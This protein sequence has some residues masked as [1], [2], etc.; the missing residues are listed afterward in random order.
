MGYREP[1]VLAVFCAVGGVA[2]AAAAT[3]TLSTT[4]ND[5]ANGLTAPLRTLQKAATLLQDGDTLVFQ[6]GTYTAGVYITRRNITLR[7]VGDVVLNGSG[8]TRDDGISFSQTSGITLEN[9]KVRNCRRMGIFVTLS[10][11]LTIRN[12]EVSAN[13]GSGILTG[14]TSD[15]LVENCAAFSNGSHGVYLSQSGDRLTVRGNRLYNNQ[16][17]GLQ[18]NAVQ[19]S[20]TSDPNS[21]SLSKN[22]TVEGNTIYGNGAVGGSAINLMGVQNSQIA[23]N[24]IYNNLAGGIALWDDGAGAAYACKNNRVLH[25]TVVFPSGKGRYGVQFLAGSTGNQLYNNILVVGAGSAI[26]AAVAVQSN[27]NCLSAPTTANGGSLSAW[28]NST[29]NDQNSQSGNP[30]LTADYHLSATSAARD[31]GYAMLGTDKDGRL[32]PQGPNPDVGCYEEIYGSTTPTPPTPPTPPPTGTATVLYA[33]ALVSGWTATSSKAQYNL[34][35]TSPV[36]TGSRSVAL[37][38]TGTDGF[39]RIA[40]AG[41]SVS[42]KSYLKLAVHGGATGGQQLRIRSIVNGVQQSNSLNLRSYGALPVANGWVEYAIPL[43]DLKAAQGTLTGLKLFAGQAE[44]LA[45]LDNIRLE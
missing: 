33:D 44:K 8:A 32:R 15:V 35:A 40:G 45:Y 21:D 11:G 38:I 10:S 2:P 19:P 12:C 34:A 25:N 20:P 41:V 9:L 37:T 5:A 28:Q 4:G 1:L 24:L 23:N 43:A 13:T 42:G 31:G 7:G 16:R 22:C 36:N 27:Y 26:E 17:A 39:L 3:Y 30:G 29:G 14:N 18:I 6:A